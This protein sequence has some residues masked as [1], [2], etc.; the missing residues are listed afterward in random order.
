METKE[1]LASA[2]CKAQ[3][4][5][6]PAA[7][8]GFNPHFKSYFSTMEDLIKATRPALTKYGIAVS[9]FPVLGETQ[10]LLATV[11]MKD[12]EQ[13]VS[14]FPILLKDPTNTQELGK[15]LSYITRYV[16]KTIL[17]IQAAVEDDDGNSSAGFSP[18]YSNDAISEK[19]VAMLKALLKS[20]PEREPKLCAHYKIQDISQLPWRY[21]NEVVKLLKGE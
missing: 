16:Y 10:S 14:H 4:E 9:Q 7:Q 20:Q 12:K 13:I 15:A 17:C 11:L 2:L 6:L 5:F 19:Q 21:M 3:S 1:T 8:T 18:T